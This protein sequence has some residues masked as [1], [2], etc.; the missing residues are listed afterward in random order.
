MRPAPTRGSSRLPALSF[1][2]AM[3][4]SAGSLALRAPADEGMW[5]LSSPP[6]QQIK[7]RYGVDITPE[8]ISHAQRA[9]VDI[10]ASGSFVSKRGLVMTNHH[11]A[12]D[13]IQKLSTPERDLIT[14]GFFAPTLA[15]ELPCPDTE[16]TILMSIRDVTGEVN[17]P[18]PGREPAQ[19]RRANITAIEDGEKTK[20]GLDASV[21]TLYAGGQYHLY[22]FKRFTDVRLVFAPE[23]QAAYFGGDTDNF[24]FPRHC[25]DVAFMRVYENGKPYE[26]EHFLKFSKE[27]VKDG[28]AIF[29]FGH[30]GRTQRL[31]T[32]EDLRQV[33]D[34]DLPQRLSMIWRVESK[35]REFMG[36]SPENARM[37]REEYFG[38]TNSRKALTGQLAGLLD[39]A[40][41]KT[42]LAESAAVF[43]TGTPKAAIA[44]EASATLASV[45]DR[46]REI[47][48]RSASI[49]RGI[50]GELGSRALRMVL[51]E[52]QLAL[53][54]GERLPEFSPSAI[55]QTEFSIL[56]PVP[57]YPA[58]EEA[59]LEWWFS[60]LT[61]RL[62][63]EDPLVQQIM[64]G[65]S[66]REL[67]QR[68]VRATALASVESRKA[69]ME[70]ASSKAVPA[71]VDPMIA[72]ARR[73]APEYTRLRRISEIEIGGKRADA[74]AKIAEARFEALGTSVY[75]DATGTLRMSYGAV[76]GVKVSTPPT[77]AFTTMAGLYELAQRR[78]DSEE[79]AVPKSWLDAKSSLVLQTPFN[80]ICTADIIGGNSGSPVINA[81][82]EVVGLIFDGNIDSLAG[83]FVYDQARNRA[84]AVD[85]RA[86][87][88]ALRKVYRAGSLADELTVP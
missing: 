79:F 41:W 33:R 24:E 68:V 86:I 76:E 75:P 20:T 6:T 23:V 37:A 83:A 19:A 50:P 27:G 34:H 54:P 21:I 17:A 88:E 4:L 78:S 25:L 36:R 66:P 67:A 84:V 74:Y 43:N 70:S 51:R 45:R 87:L 62:G 53:S 28:E 52:G 57:I 71:T 73:V 40:V 15:E 55:A 46:A 32:V 8:F 29:V 39:P 81:K 1:T 85:S 65:A 48:A 60:M 22:T 69:M 5:L 47:S 11:V 7:A 2:V 18:V 77:P 3:V 12:S 13:A 64:D 26:P 42:K 63:G 38:W 56:A 49:A 31:L 72:L 14:N 10:G 9:C 44:I 59:Q 35:L 30:P 58:F 16:V 61:E 82:G 80:F